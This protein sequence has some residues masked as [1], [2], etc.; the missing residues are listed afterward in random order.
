MKRALMMAGVVMVVAVA[1]VQ[2]ADTVI[3]H[4]F[5]G[6]V[7]VTNDVTTNGN[8]GL[9]TGTCYVA[10]PVTGL[11]GLVVGD[12]LATTNGDVRAHAAAW[13]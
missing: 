11:T 1:I 3:G 8:T 2:A 10:F 5:P 4:Y 6:Y 13:M 9:A 12:A 7:F